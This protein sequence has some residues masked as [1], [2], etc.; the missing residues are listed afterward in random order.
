MKLMIKAQGYNISLWFPTSL[1]KSR[2]AYRILQHA[3]SGGISKQTRTISTEH[4]TEQQEPI[5]NEEKHS[6]VI[7]R[8]QQLKLY[9]SLKQYI[10]DNGHFNLIEVESHN[11][12]KVR[13]RV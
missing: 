3:V 7:T 13:L 6:T 2:I 8:K 5:K 10:K 4:V 12:E 9:N 11:G 1:L